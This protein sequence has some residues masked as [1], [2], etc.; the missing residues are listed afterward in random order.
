M[1]PASPRG[2]SVE[3]LGMFMAF[4]ERRDR[5]S[6]C[7]EGRRLHHMAGDTW[8][9]DGLPGPNSTLRRLRGRVLRRH[10]FDPATKRVVLLLGS[11]T[12]TWD[13]SNWTESIPAQ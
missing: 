11:V 7:M 1:D 2:V 10:A 3:A 6:C 5:R 4:D 8:T 9:W 13:G 12:W